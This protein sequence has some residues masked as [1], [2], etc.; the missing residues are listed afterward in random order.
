MEKGY[1]KLKRS[2]RGTHQVW[3]SMEMPPRVVRADPRVRSAIG[4]IA[5]MRGPVVYCLEEAD[6]GND[7]H[8]LEMAADA[9]LTEMRRDDLAA[10]MIG[11]RA[12]GRG[13]NDGLGAQKL[14]IRRQE[15]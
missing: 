14:T 12:P 4:K 9:P 7:L 8:G 3:I 1:W 2:W 5:V 6:N 13:R 10:G 11:I 15:G